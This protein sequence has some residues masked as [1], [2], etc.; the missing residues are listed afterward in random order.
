ML[1]TMR[2]LSQISRFKHAHR[3]WWLVAIFLFLFSIGSSVT[4]HLLHAQTTDESTETANEEHVETAESTDIDSQAE[5]SAASGYEIGISLNRVRELVDLGTTELAYR[6]IAEARSEYDQTSDWMEWE[7]LYLELAWQLEAWNDLIERASQLEETEISHLA[8]TFAIRAEIHLKRYSNALRNIR[9]LI[10][11]QSGDQDSLIQLRRLIAQLYV[12]EE[13][14]EDAE[15]ALALYDRDYRPSAPEWEHRYTRVLFRNNKLDEA[16][17]RLSPLQTLEAQLL[18]LYARFQTRASSP[19]ETVLKGLEIEPQFESDP[20]LHAELWALIEVA[21]R[22]YNDFEMQTEAIESG[23]SI[24][25]PQ[26]SKWEHLPVVPLNTEIQLLETYDNFAFFVGN[27]IGL[28]IGDDESWFQLAQEFEITSPITAR[29]V[30]AY[31]ARNAYGSEYKERSTRALANLL[32]E[33]GLQNLLDRLFVRNNL[34]DVSKVSHELQT[35]LANTLLKQ[36]DYEKA[37]SIIN[38]MAKPEEP[39]QLE[40]WYLTQARIAISIGEYDR[41]GLLLDEAISNLPLQAEQSAIDRI[42]Q[43]VYDLQDRNQH[44]LAIQFFV[45]LYDKATETQDRRELLRW[46]SESYS[47]MEDY[48]NAS[49]HLLRSAQLGNDW[50]DEWGIAARLK[51][52]DEMVNAGFINDARV[53]YTQLHDD[54]LDPRTRALISNR[55][56][57]LPVSDS[58]SSQ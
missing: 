50:N 48:V 31:L 11:D 6:L 36:K 8:Q 37:L 5:S 28:V 57:G 20:E 45:K 10:L 43:V 44:D 33:A 52:G 51:A 38:V 26:L 53:I 56:H 25:Y 46:I 12:E 49:E 32:Y 39:A 4:P 23:L 34:L 24:D 35:R 58:V 54:A 17:I 19:A 30:H 2:S 42:K 55:L 14:L 40:S 29:A 27:D 22:A 41:S 16:E 21:A 3:R 1:P 18:N 13:N 7:T 15:I 9:A 47:A